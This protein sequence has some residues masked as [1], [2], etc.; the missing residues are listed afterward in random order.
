MDTK[1]RF[2]GN[3]LKVILRS[4]SDYILPLVVVGGT[5][6]GDTGRFRVS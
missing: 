4:F 2:A 5:F 3:W 6:Y 1:L